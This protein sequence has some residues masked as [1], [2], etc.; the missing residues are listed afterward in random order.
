MSISLGK[1]PMETSEP[2]YNHLFG[3]TWDLSGE[4]GGLGEV[5]GQVDLTES[6]DEVVLRKPTPAQIRQLFFISVIIKDKLTDLCGN[7]LLQNNFTK[8]LPTLD[9]TQSN[10]KLTAPRQTTDLIVRL[11][12]GWKFLKEKFDILSENGFSKQL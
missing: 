12:S 9:P 7:W 5:A 8:N 3:S 6:V 4:V 1:E 2:I 10:Q 11:K